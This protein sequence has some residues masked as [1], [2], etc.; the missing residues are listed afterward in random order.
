MTLTVIILSLVNG[1]Q[2]IT[3]PLLSNDQT[4]LRISCAN[5]LL[6]D[7]LMLFTFDDPAGLTLEHLDYLL[8][9]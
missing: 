8:N 2:A 3:I 5:T 1:F 7:E 6:H 4:T 9:C